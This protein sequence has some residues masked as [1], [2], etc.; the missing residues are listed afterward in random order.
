MVQ[1][2]LKIT[3]LRGGT[4][5]EIASFMTDMENAYNSFYLFDDGL[6]TTYTTRRYARRLLFYDELLYNGILTPN[7]R[8]GDEIIPINRLELS[9][10]SIQSPGFWEF[11]GQLNPLQQIREFLKDRHEMRKDREYR[12][13]AEKERL[14]LD[15]ELLQRQVW[16]KDHAI[17][18]EQLSM[19]K[20]F[21]VDEQSIRDAA[22]SRLG[23]PLSR[24]GQ[25][26]DRGL[27]AGPV[28][29]Q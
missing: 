20:E 1:G 29:E 3:G 12:E 28:D 13:V 26:Q 10:V 11:L 18:R 24:L 22:W 23:P 16:E 2:N 19:M 6:R 4:A 5:V 21:G 15:N 8:T 17:L 9:R 14:T 27:I 25:H 7:W